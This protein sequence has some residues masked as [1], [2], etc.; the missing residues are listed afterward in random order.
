MNLI[1]VSD[2]QTKVQLGEV[3]VDRDSH[4]GAIDQAHRYTKI[5]AESLP[6]AARRELRVRI[7]KASGKH[8]DAYAEICHGRVTLWD[9]FL[10]EELRCGRN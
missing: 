10:D 3:P 8:H 2:L 1:I 9:D 4:E 6:N 5:L 7:F